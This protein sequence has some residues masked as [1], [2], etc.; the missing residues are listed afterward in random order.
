MAPDFTLVIVMRS[1]LVIANWKMHGS[2]AQ[3]Q[4]FASSLQQYLAAEDAVHCKAVI[5]PPDLFLTAMRQAI[6]QQRLNVSI[7][8]QNLCAEEAEQGAYTGETSA[9]M[10]KAEGAEFVLLGHS[11]R[12]TYYAES[13]AVVAAKCR[14]ALAQ[15]L[16][17]VLCVGET[18]EEREAGEA[19]SLIARQLNVVYQALGADMSKLL[20]AYEPVW[21]IGT[22]KTATP[23]QAQEI[24]GFIRQCLQ[25]NLGN[26]ASQSML[27]LYGGS[28]KASNAAA[29]FAKDDIDGALV[30]GA[31]LIANEFANIIKAA[32]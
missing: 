22:G 7:G 18:L 19:Q 32:K 11:E 2:A 8:G 10:L 1:Q 13:D 21:A 28:V 26:D 12:R 20:I 29:L 6:Q 5:C 25:E 23:E 14:Q 27:V 9:K 24:H 4:D 15:Q 17:P 31:S 30:G 16:T 3:V